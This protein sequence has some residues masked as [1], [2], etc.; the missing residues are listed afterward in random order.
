MRPSKI[1]LRPFQ[2]HEVKL[3]HHWMTNPEIT[4]PYVRGET[5]AL[6]ELQKEFQETGWRTPSLSRWICEDLKKNI[7]GVAQAW[8]FDLYEDHMEVGRVLLPEFRGHGL[9]TALMRELFNHVFTN[10][11]CGRAQAMTPCDN[12]ATIRTWEKC[13]M[14]V[15]G[16]LRNFITVGDKKLDCFI[17]SILRSD[18]ESQNP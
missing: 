18:W 16:R 9:G 8:K 11:Q 3:Y 12:A 17:A 4:G 2:A 5:S 6:L 10:Y 1:I 13:G 7:V 15:E 14:T